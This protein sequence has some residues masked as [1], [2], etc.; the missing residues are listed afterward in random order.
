MSDLDCTGDIGPLHPISWETKWPMYSFN[1]PS[2]TVWGSIANELHAKGW[3][4]AK[5]KTWLQSTEARW[6]MDSSLGD[7]LRQVAK[8]YAA[9]II[10]GTAQ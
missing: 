7:A 2:F 9:T 8:D 5:I 4:E 10:K 6:A 3:S 1:A